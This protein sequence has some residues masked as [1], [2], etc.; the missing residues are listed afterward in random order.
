MKAYPV[1]KSVF[2]PPVTTKHEQPTTTFPS[3]A[4]TTSDPATKLRSG[5][6]ANN[7]CDGS[8]GGRISRDEDPLDPSPPLPRS[9]VR[10]KPPINLDQHHRHSHHSHHN[11]RSA[12]GIAALVANTVFA[13]NLTPGECSFHAKAAVAVDAATT[14]I[15]ITV[16]PRRIHP[17]ST[18]PTPPLT[19]AAEMAMIT[20]NPVDAAITAVSTQS[21]YSWVSGSFTEG[22][23]RR[24]YQRGR[25]Q[26]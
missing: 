2:E 16:H 11:P 14:A 19:A 23:A 4:S 21:Y 24:S 17:P 22:G 7:S 25:R 6:H 5:S 8:C 3:I 18:P 10:P 1:V 12:A 9:Q 26:A 20:I 13:G 15:T